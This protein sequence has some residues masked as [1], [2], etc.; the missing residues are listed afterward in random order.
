LKGDFSQL[1]PKAIVEY[2][3]ENGYGIC[4]TQTRFMELI[5]EPMDHEIIV[6]K[7]LPKNNKQ[8]YKLNLDIEI[9]EKIANGDYENELD[10]EIQDN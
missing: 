1:T 8:I 2:I 4:N 7:M 3:L 5:F 10:K 9:I 6:E